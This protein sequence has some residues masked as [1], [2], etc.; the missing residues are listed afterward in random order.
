M[1]EEGQ[2]RL[3]GASVLVTRVGGLGGVVAYELAAAGVGRLVIA[4]AGTIKPGDLN[5]QIL[6]T[7][8]AL[9]TSRVECAAQRLREL[10]PRLDIVTVAENANA[11]NV[12]RLVKLVDVVVCCAPMYE[13][14]LAM[15]EQCVRQRRPMVDCAMYELTGQITTILPGRTACLA[16]RVP[17]PPASWKRFFPV[18]GAVAGTVGCLGAMEAIKLITGIGEPLANRLLTYDLREVRFRTIGL[19][20]RP[21][22]KVCGLLN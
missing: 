20:R 8:A 22:C 16:C 11:E 18:F 19:K 2:R 10:N 1:G 12:E 9:G 21:D 15:N 5:R 17:E 4:H 7:H 13:E 3:K 6:M 14:R